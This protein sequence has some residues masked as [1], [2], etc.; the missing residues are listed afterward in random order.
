M[1]SDHVALKTLAL[2]TAGVVAIEA[3]A[4]WGISRWGLAPL[5]GTALARLIDMAWLALVISGCP[6]GWAR[7]G[8]IR[9]KLAARSAPGSHLVGGIRRSGRRSGGLY[10][11]PQESIP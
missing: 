2:A 8:L 9:A 6:Q 7:I 11:S 10:S 4:R 3:L 1:E 5:T